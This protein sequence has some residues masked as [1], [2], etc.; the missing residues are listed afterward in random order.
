[1]CSLVISQSF[2]SLTVQRFNDLTIQRLSHNSD[3]MPHARRAE[4]DVKIGEHDG[5]EAAPGPEHVAAIEATGAEVSLLPQRG[6]R[7]LVHEPANQMAQRMAAKSIAGQEND[8]HCQN[9]GAEAEAEVFFACGGI[10]EPEGLP[11]VVTEKADEQDCQVEK[12]AMDVLQ[13]EREGFF[14]AIGLAGVA[15]GAGRRGGP[16]GC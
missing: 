16:E 6:A 10:G 1:F 14:A 2:P 11:Y 4:A 3:V 8:V 7:R 15:D 13:D 5:A 9:D 12:V